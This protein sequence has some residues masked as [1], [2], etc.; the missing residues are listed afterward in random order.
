MCYTHIFM[1]LKKSRIHNYDLVSHNF[2]ISLFVKKEIPKI[3][4][5]TA[6]ILALDSVGTPPLRVEYA[7]HCME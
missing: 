7:S 6:E 2:S 4:R 3:Q 1:D 5:I